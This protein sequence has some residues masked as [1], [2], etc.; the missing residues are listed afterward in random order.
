MANT[1]SR[2]GLLALGLSLATGGAG[3]APGQGR[4]AERWAFDP[5][6]SVRIAVP[7]GSVHVFGWDKDSLE[8]VA[9]LAPGAGRFYGVGDHRVR[10]LGVETPA[11][12]RGGDTGRAKFEVYVPRRASVWVKSAAADI[13]VTGVDG[14]LDLNAVSGTILVLGTPQ[15]VTAE[16]MNGSIEIAGGTGR[17]RVKTVSGGILLRGASQEL[18]ASTLSGSIVVRAA[19]WQRGGTGVQRGRFE[20]VTGDIRFD[21]Q[22]GRGGALEIESQSGN[23]E[24]RVPAQTVADF[25]AVTIGGTI[26]NAL[27][28]TPPATRAAGVGQEL[29]FSTGTGGA[30]VTVRNFKGAIV[31]TPK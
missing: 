5:G 19:G 9:A 4:I 21:G 30:Q 17:A 10:K 25:D 2:V 22:L 1:M 26:T 27:D 18:A 7:F 16:S 20:S 15:D 31:L 29:H 28:K 8:V 12:A 13:E 11:G 3:A 6:G 24:V 23:I 14:V